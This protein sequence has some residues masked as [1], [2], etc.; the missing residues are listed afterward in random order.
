MQIY[1]T[2]ME[3]GGIRNPY[4]GIR[5]NDRLYQRLAKKYKLNENS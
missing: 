5:A 3:S 1:K 2:M 4:T